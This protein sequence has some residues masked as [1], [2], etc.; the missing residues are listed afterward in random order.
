MGNAKKGGTGM[1]L[2]FLDKLHR[3]FLVG[4]SLI[5]LSAP[6]LASSTP[7]HEALIIMGAPGEELYKSKF[8]S[9]VESWKTACEAANASATVVGLEDS[10]TANRESIQKWITKLDPESAVPAWIVYIGHGSSNRRETMLNLNGPDLDSKT[11]ATWLEPIKRPV[12][13]I[14]GGSSSAAFIAD[15]SSPGRTIISATKSIDE[16]NYARFGELFAQVIGAQTG[17]LDEDGQVSV[18]E[19]FIE[20]SDLTN[21]FYTESGR[22]VSEHALI[23]DNGDGYGT[24]SSFFQGTRI[25]KRSTDNRDPDGLRARQIA[26]IPSPEERLLSPEQKLE[27]D[28]IEAELEVLRTQKSDMNEEEYYEQLEGILLRLS[29]IYAEQED[30]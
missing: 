19:A 27:R 21:K 18:L 30:S 15:L 28:K 16:I 22:L 4:I 12:I 6:L 9:A 14:H 1:I 11:L 26:L 24:P 8:E 2:G 20:A 3:A 13:F 23:D 25:T 7:N 5:G 17:D 10:D 29:E